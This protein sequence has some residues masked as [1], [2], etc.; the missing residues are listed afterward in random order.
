MIRQGNDIMLSHQTA[1]WPMEG[2]SFSLKE[3]ESG[4]LRWFE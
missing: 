1:S 4:L 2:K 3:E